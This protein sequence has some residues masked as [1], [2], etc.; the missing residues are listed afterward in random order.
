[1]DILLIEP[2]NLEASAYTSLLR[3]SGFKV[4]RTVSAQTAIRAVD[5]RVPDVIILEL[6]M[7]RHNGVE[8]LY[9]LRSYSEWLSVPVIIHSYASPSEFNHGVALKTELGVV[10]TL[11]KPKSSLAQLV[12][13]VQ[14]VVLVPIT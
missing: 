2:D 4:R 12:E 9:E 3:A 13:T 10:A 14:A 7:P 8:F 11:Y 5:K 1:M 6:Q